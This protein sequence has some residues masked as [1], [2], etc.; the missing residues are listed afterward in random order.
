MLYECLIGLMPVFDWPVPGVSMP[1]SQV[2]NIYIHTKVNTVESKTRHI[3]LEKMN[4]TRPGSPAH[5][6][7]IQSYTG[8]CCSNAIPGTQIKS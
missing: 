4:R 6:I 8:K 3:A 2:H 5:N 1:R 7:Y